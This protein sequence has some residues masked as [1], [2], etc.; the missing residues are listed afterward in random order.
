MI[1]QV[2]TAKLF[3]LGMAAVGDRVETLH[4]AN[5]YYVPITH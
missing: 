3:P 4:S 5:V 1:A 2:D